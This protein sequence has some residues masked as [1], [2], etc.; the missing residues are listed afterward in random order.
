MSK[1]VREESEFWWNEWLVL[2]IVRRT[3]N[4]EEANKKDERNQK[5]KM[6]LCGTSSGYYLLTT[7]CIA[8]LLQTHDEPFP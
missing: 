1:H 3:E 8:D 7:T 4:E 6:C 2:E 5:V